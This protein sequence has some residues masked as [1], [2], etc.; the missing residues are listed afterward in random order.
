VTRLN[1]IDFFFL[2]SNSNLKKKEKTVSSSSASSTS[3]TTSTTL[4]STTTTN[5]ISHLKL[6]QN[7]IDNLSTRCKQSENKL[8]DLIQLLTNVPDP[9]PVIDLVKQLANENE[10]YKQIQT[11]QLENKDLRETLHA[12]KEEINLMNN[13]E[14]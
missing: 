9:F 4:N 10:L 7:E 3:N 1:K 12:Y 5:T 8:V 11:L 14:V 2:I 6:F 13:K